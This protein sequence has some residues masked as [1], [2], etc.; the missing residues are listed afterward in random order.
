MQLFSSLNEV[1]FLDLCVSLYIFL[2]L[3]CFI[4]FGLFVLA[5]LGCASSTPNEDIVRFRYGECDMPFLH[6]FCEKKIQFFLVFLVLGLFVPFLFVLDPYLLSY[7]FVYKW[8]MYDM[9]LV[10]SVIFSFS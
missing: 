1:A 10:Y 9:A 3:V 2:Y 8:N 4:V 7:Y 5:V 6:I